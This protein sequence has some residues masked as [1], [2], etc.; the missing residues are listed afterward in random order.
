MSAS[1]TSMPQTGGLPPPIPIPAMSLQQEDSII[2]T[3][4]TN[5]EKILRKVTKKFF[6]Y[7]TVAYNTAVTA[8]P[9]GSVA[10]DDARE[11]FLV[12][13][14][15]FNLS[16]KKSLMVCEAEA[17]Q[18]EEY[19]RER[20]RIENE[21][22]SLTEQ[23]EALKVSLEQAQ[24][25]RRRKIEYDVIAEK[26]NTLPTREELEQS[27]TAIENDILATQAEH[28]N[29]N[30]IL[31]AQQLAL[32]VVI[33]SIQDLRIMGKQDA[34]VTE[35]SR[36]GTPVPDSQQ[37]EDDDVDMEPRQRAETG[38]ISDEKEDLQDTKATASSASLSRI[39]NPAVKAFLP[40]SSSPS[41]PLLRSNAGTPLPMT[42][43]QSRTEL[44]EGEDDDIE[45]GELAEEPIEKLKKK[46]R[47]EELEEGEASDMSSELSEPPDD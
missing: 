16:L 10:I 21:H 44:E 19:Q 6:H 40:Q 25:Q 30:N 33:S 11:S 27:I 41:T 31:H 13:L 32:E 22:A 42:D 5:D 15:S 8:T 3:R 24:L 36:P 23:I 12:E 17:R 2:H 43:S 37:G 9:E 39:L 14:A 34:D 18:I 29:Q 20:E 4:I 26:I 45:M 1:Q 28:E 35:T 7:T 47:E 46:A 38:E